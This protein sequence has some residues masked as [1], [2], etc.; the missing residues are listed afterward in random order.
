MTYEL[1]SP[2]DLAGVV[3]ETSEYRRTHFRVYDEDGFMSSFATDAPKGATLESVTAYL[4]EKFHGTGGTGFQS[5]DLVVLLGARIVA[6]IR[7]GPAGCPEL[8]TFA[9]D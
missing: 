5:K 7:K 9:D 2:A 1:T 6:V 8:T 3:R 4:I